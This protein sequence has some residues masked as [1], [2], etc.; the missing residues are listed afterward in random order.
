MFRTHKSPGWNVYDLNSVTGET[1]QN[2][3][4]YQ[5]VRVYVTAYLGNS[6]RKFHVDI[7]FANEITP[8]AIEAQYFTLLNRP[9]FLI[10]GY[11]YETSIA[12]KLHAMITL[13]LANDRLK[14]FYDIWLIAHQFNVKGQ[15]LVD[16][17]TNT[18]RARK[19]DIPH[20]VPTVF[21]DPFVQLKKTGWLG[22]KRKLPADDP[23]PA[24]FEQVI[25][26]LQEF[27]MPPLQAAADQKPYKRS[28]NATK[29]WKKD[30]SR[31][32]K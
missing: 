12:E 9:S 17:I 15:P 3:A 14:D 7:S 13:D 32:H 24:D 22:F 4:D 11:P 19:T 6:Y 21:T 26:M 2:D 28:W 25:L 8:G 27:L 1:I 20:D 30:S 23:I 5:G 29:G 18:F 10:K 31:K 16:A